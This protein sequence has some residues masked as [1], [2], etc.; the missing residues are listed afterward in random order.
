MWRESGLNKGGS[1]QTPS[2]E[3]RRTVRSQGSHQDFGALLNHVHLS[4]SNRPGP[5]PWP[6][7]FHRSPEPSGYGL[8]GE[9]RV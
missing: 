3:R 1:G 5:R 4:D 8:C 7:R 6:R 9:A 2:Q